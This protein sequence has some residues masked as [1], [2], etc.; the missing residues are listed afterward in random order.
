MSGDRLDNVI[1]LA[2]LEQPRYDR[3]PQVVEP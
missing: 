2:G 3:V 1:G